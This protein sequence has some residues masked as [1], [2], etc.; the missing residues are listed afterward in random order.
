MSAKTISVQ[1]DEGAAA[2]YLAFNGALV[3]RGE[4]VTVP[5]EVGENLIEQGWH[6][7]SK[8]SKPSAKKT[9]KPESSETEV[10]NTTE[11]DTPK[12]ND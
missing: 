6:E 1:Y 2:V 8:S 4:P 9:T 12:E 5:V 7:A 10:D 11:A 3:N